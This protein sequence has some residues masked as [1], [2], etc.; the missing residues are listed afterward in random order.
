MNPTWLSAVVEAMSRVRPPLGQ[1]RCNGSCQ[2]L[3]GT[4]S[5]SNGEQEWIVSRT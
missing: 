2:P 1:I 3:V 4:K 5:V